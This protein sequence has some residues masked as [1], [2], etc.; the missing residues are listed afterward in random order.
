MS[1]SSYFPENFQSSLPIILLAGR[2]DYPRLVWERMEKLCPNARIFSFEPEQSEWL[3]NIPKERWSTFE[4]GQVGT[5]LKAL[6]QCEAKYVL[7]AGQIRP[8]K[9]F[10]GLNPDLKALFLLSRLKEKNATTI[11]GALLAEIENLGIEILDARC[12]MEEHLATAG[13]L[14][15]K[16]YDSVAPETLQHGIRIC[17][18]IAALDIG[19]SVVVRNGI[20]LLA[21]GFDGTDAM[22]ERVASICKDG[23]G[24]VKAAKITQDFR[25]DVPIFGLRTL[26]KMHASNIRW[27]AL[28]SGRTIILD[29]KSVLAEADRLKITVFGFE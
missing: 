17:R 2:G 28:E 9:L 14:T 6:R 13:L 11:Y 5:W 25:Y 18:G 7:L 29:K 12:F 1:F 20:T 4:I 21:E 27:A 8:K 19:Q 3:Q 15:K 10:H 26:Q 16:A 23:M 22:I 24:L